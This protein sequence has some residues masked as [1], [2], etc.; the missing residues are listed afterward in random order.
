VTWAELTATA[1]IDGK[2]QR[3]AT[4]HNAPTIGADWD[5]SIADPERRA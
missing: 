5:M 4:A 3:P 2:Q 1:A